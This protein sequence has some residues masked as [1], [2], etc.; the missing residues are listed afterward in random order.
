[1][2]SDATAESPGQAIAV[3]I[4]GLLAD[5]RAGRQMNPA[6]AASNVGNDT[7]RVGY[8][9]LQTAAEVEEIH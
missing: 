4:P 1:M 9:P 7:A 3:A 2:R 8:A 5:P 6:H